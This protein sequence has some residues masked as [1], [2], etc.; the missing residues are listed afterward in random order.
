MM[1]KQPLVTATYSK[2]TPPNNG[3]G[4]FML[5]MMGACVGSG[6][7]LLIVSAVCQL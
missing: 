7:T 2:E 4:A 6:L 5:F 1:S 3:T